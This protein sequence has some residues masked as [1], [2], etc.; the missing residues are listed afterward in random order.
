MKNPIRER[1]SQGKPS[2]G[3][4][5]NLASP[6][7]A[8][9]M[10]SVGV[11]W[12]VV[13]A[14]HTAFDLD[15]VVHTFRAIEARGAM[16]M[17]RAWNH[18]VTTLSRLL[19]AGAWGL[20]IP[21]VSTPQQA[22][23]LANAMRFPPRG[24]RSAGSGRCMTFARGR[25]YFDFFDDE[26]LCIPQIEDM[27]GIENAEQIANVDG[28]DI[29]FLGPGDLALSMGVKAGHPDHEQ[30]IGRFR[31][32]FARAGKPCGIPVP[33]A[34]AARQR[35]DEGFQLID[36]SND[37]ALLRSKVEQEFSEFL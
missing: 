13:D 24:T 36:M 11:P 27:Q 21:H 2:V 30:A 37:L 3:G 33:N 4:W 10:A 7:A 15:L 20:V 31:E 28:V 6:L 35:I 34:A 18:E 14:E 29:G 22:H 17:A 19:D 12:L 23:T 9:A 26:V 32:A 16:P 1:L 25:G 5:L 8:E